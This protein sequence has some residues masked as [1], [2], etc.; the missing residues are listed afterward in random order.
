MLSE[1]DRTRVLSQPVATEEK[2]DG[3]NVVLWVDDH[4]VQ[5]ALRSGP[6]G[7][8][9]GRQL[10]PLRA[11]MAE[12]TDSLLAL[13]E[14]D[15]LALYA[16]WLLLTHTTV[17]D[18]LP[19]YLLALDLRGAGGEFLSVDDRN[20]R[21][22]EHGVAHPPDL[23]RG[24]PGTVETVEAQLGP[25]RVGSVPAEGLIVRAPADGADPRLAKVWRPG[26]TPLDDAEWQGGRPRNLLADR[27][28]SWH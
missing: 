16:E 25:S 11:W 14:P 12:R 13:L 26:F 28:R 23:W 7:A 18:Q 3:A 10:G 2:L 24:V 17:Y 8:N 19:D 27:D 6:G 9:R 5:C 20:R 21:C 15:G 4:V 22:D 1:R